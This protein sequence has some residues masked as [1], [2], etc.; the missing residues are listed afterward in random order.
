MTVGLTPPTLL[1]DVSVTLKYTEN[2]RFIDIPIKYCACASSGYQALSSCGWGLGTRLGVAPSTRRTYQAGI[3]RF[4]QFCTSYNLQPLP[5]SPLTLRYLCAY[6][7]PSVQHS[8]IKLYLTALRLFHVEH[9]YTDPTKDCLLQS[10]TTRPRLP[11][12]IQLLRDLKLALHNCTALTTPN[13]RM[14]WAAFCVAFYGFLRASKFCSPSSH[15]FDPASTLCHTD[16]TFTP[17]A[18]NLCIKASK[19]DPFRITCTIT[20][21]ATHTST[22]PVKALQNYLPHLT[23]TLLLRGRLLP[24]PH[25]PHSPAPFAPAGGGAGPRHICKTLI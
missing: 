3:N 8:T 17:A 12:T 14:L 11:I 21:G 16:L 20:I 13:K 4:T 25:L 22:C 1:G 2:T 9:S 6:L 18:A 19:T 5:A 7:S 24:H 10:T 15:T 23:P